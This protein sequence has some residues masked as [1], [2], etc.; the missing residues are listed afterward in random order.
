MTTL[1]QFLNDKIIDCERVFENANTTTDMVFLQG[2]LQH[3]GGNQ[4]CLFC[5][6]YQGL[7]EPCKQG[8]RVTN[9]QD[10]LQCDYYCYNGE[11]NESKQ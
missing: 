7:D 5:T 6:E 8:V 9:I 1:N 2:M 10:T 11:C 4:F 3:G